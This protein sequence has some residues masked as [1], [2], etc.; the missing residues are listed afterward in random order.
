MS[1]SDLIRLTAT[2]AVTLLKRGEITPLDL[3]EAAA[4]RIEAVDDQVNALPI[5][6]YDRARDHA[7]QLASGK[8]RE[9][10]DHPGWLAGLPIAIKD[11]M[12][13]EGTLNTYGGSP[14][15]AD[16]VS[17]TSDVLV[18][19]L[20][21]R[22]GI[23][24]AKSASPEFGALPVTWNRLHGTTRTPWD[25]RLH[26]GGSSGGGAAAVASGEVWLGHGSDIGGSLRIP[27]SF[28]GVVG[29]RPSAG[30]VPRGVTSRAF[31]PLAVQGPMAR[32]VADC[33]LFLDAMAGWW[34]GDPLSL[35]DPV[36]PFAKLAAEPKVPLRVGFSVD[37]GYA[38]IDP[39]V[40]EICAAAAKRFAEAGASVDEA[41]FDLSETPD[42]YSILYPMSVLGDRQQY[43]E[44]NRDRAFA[45]LVASVENAKRFTVDDIVRAER[46]RGRLVTKAAA[47]FETFDV[48]VTPTLGTPP[49]GIEER[50]PGNAEA[51]S[52][53]FDFPW[54]APCCATVLIGA[55]VIA[56][57]A[58]F[59][60]DGRPVG[61][62]IVG[63]PRDEAGI[64]QAAATLESILGLHRQLPIDPREARA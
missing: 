25:T 45:G 9:Q 3:V 29:L 46:G 61:L 54:I 35:P 34:Q 17:K 8:G 49:F 40:A 44:G 22:G 58:G 47:A 56:I 32:T 51:N 26:A 55:P 4:A 37:L 28:C 2:D 53:E 57:P 12:D 50:S 38:K 5:R 18:K 60:R 13:V 7:K 16:N 63:K 42:I 14:V 62:Q 11:L 30:R 52:L 64:I 15:Y 36:V 43:A 1:E 21:A 59:T 19:R 6:C 27:A 39:E 10:Q 41:D 31:N 24:V 33:A 23:V 48:I 20:E